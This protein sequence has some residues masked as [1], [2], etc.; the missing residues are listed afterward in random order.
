[1]NYDDEILLAL[2]GCVSPRKA[3]Q[4]C[5]CLGIERNRK[6]GWSN[7]AYAKYAAVG[8]ALQRLK[9]AG[10]VRYVTGKGAGWKLVNK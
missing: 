10:K 3:E 9:R 1:M 8:S 6:G 2:R 7:A 4:I 5:A